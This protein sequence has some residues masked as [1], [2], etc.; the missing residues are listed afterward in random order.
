M[1]IPT[2]LTSP[3]KNAF[4]CTFIRSIAGSL[5]FLLARFLSLSL[6]VL[7][8]VHVAINSNQLNLITNNMNTGVNGVLKTRWNSVICYRNVNQCVMATAYS[9]C[10]IHINKNVYWENFQRCTKVLFLKDCATKLNTHTHISFSRFM[11]STY[12]RKLFESIFHMRINNC[13]LWM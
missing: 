4:L 13:M 1:K 10:K 7:W 8:S 11:R 6:S 2:A 12:N 3:E 9:S 5:S